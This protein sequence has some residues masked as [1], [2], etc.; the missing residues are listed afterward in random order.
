MK[1]LANYTMKS[2]RANKVRTAVT[3]LGVALAAALLTAVF[4]SYTSFVNLLYQSEVATSG[5]WMISA[6]SEAGDAIME[7]AHQALEDPAVT[8]VA[9]LR[10]V[11]FAELAEEQQESLGQYQPIMS[12][13]GDVGRLLGVKASEGRL[14]ERAG[15]IMLFKVWNTQEGVQLGDDITFSMGTRVAVAAAGQGEESAPVQDGAERAGEPTAFEPEVVSGSIA[16]GSSLDSSIGYLNAKQDEGDLDERLVDMHDQTYQV[17]GFYDRVGYGMSVGVGT[18]AL[19]VDDPAASGYAE[20]YLTLAGMKTADD[21]ERTT[22]EL[23]PGAS[24]TLHVAILRYMGIV[25]DTSM[26]TTFS[27]LVVVL[28]VIII[29]A[30]VSLIFNAFNISVAERMKQFGLLCSVGAT[31]GQLRR[32]VLLEAFVVALIGIPVG[33]AVGLGGCG[34]TFALLDPAFQELAGGLTVPFTIEADPWMLGISAAFT[35]VAVLVSAWIPA[36]RASHMNIIEAIRTTGAARISKRGELRAAKAT[37]PRHLWRGGGVAGRVFGMG[38]KLAYANRKRSKTKGRAASV[39]L[40]LAVVL[41]MTA[42]SLTT[43][44]FGLIDVAMGGDPA[45]EVSVGVR[46]AQDREIRGDSADPAALQEARNKALA[47]EAAIFQGAYDEFAV[48]PH[49]DPVGW[50]LAGEATVSLPESMVGESFAQDADLE[51]PVQGH[52]GL[53]AR[54]RICYVADPQFDEYVRGLGLD[55]E[56]FRNEGVPRAVGITQA[57]GNNGSVYQ[58]LQ[59]LKEKGIMQIMPAMADES[60]LPVEVFALAEKAPAVTGGPGQGIC[61]IVPMSLAYHVNLLDEDPL[62]RSYFDATDGDHEQLAQELSDVGHELFNADRIPYTISFVTYNDYQAEADS[63]RMLATVVNVFC[64]LFTVI[65]A[66][67]AMANVFNTVT[68]SLILRRREFAVMRSVGLSNGQFRRMIVDECATFGIVGFIPGL[69]ISVAVSFMLWFMVSQ[70][71]E[72]LPFALPW[73]YLGIAVVMTVLIMGISVAYGMHR[74]KA[75]NVVEALRA[76]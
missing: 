32:T 58:L 39:S 10:D 21:V 74:C 13:E 19:T 37:D 57:Y 71:I 8:G 42:G 29:G 50:Y 59:V 3:I 26:W 52:E 66:L 55:P 15:E 16:P 1:G 51:V 27:G 53:F 69:L 43:F 25:S 18:V 44:L 47:E 70:S 17:V 41:L 22:Q 46:L 12:A 2:L 30:C 65:L 45:G 54:A 35:L 61:L 56:A 4:T 75:D 5:D 49:A 48:L 40:A 38:G 76:E 33:M 67:I 24:T 14:P 23:F 73:G 63:N 28:A 68:N 11:G 9:T 64:L 7:E 72:G 36:Q 6:A 62:F 60:A 34:I 20:A 31:R